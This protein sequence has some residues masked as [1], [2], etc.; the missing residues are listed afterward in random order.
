[1]IIVPDIDAEKA[2]HW[3]WHFGT[4][5][6]LSEAIYDAA[7]RLGLSIHPRTIVA[8]ARFLVANRLEVRACSG[9]VVICGQ[10]GPTT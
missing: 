10:P 4:C 3:G 1:M 8:E 9:A 2:R 5:F 6:A 7:H